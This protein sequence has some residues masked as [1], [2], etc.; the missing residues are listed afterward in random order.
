MLGTGR[1]FPFCASCA[2]CGCCRW[3]RMCL[4]LSGHLVSSLISVIY[5]C[6]FLPLAHND[7]YIHKYEHYTCIVHH[8]HNREWIQASRQNKV[9]ILWTTTK[10]LHHSDAKSMH[11]ATRTNGTVSW[12]LWAVKAT[13]MCQSPLATSVDVPVRYHLDLWSRERPSSQ[14]DCFDK[15]DVPENLTVSTILYS[16]RGNVPMIKT[17]DPVDVQMIYIEG[18]RSPRRQGALRGSG[19]A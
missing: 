18:L 8:I 16:S 12:S 6:V 15:M 7:V 14:P 2:Y 9:I 3:G 19:V 13:W 4:S 11:F 17:Y 1:H 5:S 10:Y